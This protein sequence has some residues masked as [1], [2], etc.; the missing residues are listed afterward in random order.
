MN[1][2]INILKDEYHYIHDYNPIELVNSNY[3]SILEILIFMSYRE[4]LAYVE[5]HIRKLAW[6]KN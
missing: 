6:Y 5:I 1:T 4:E 3:H 2:K